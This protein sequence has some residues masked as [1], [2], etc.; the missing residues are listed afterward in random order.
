MYKNVNANI[1]NSLNIH[2]KNK[3]M[4]LDSLSLNSP[5]K[6]FLCTNNTKE[7]SCEFKNN[8]EKHSEMN[9]KSSKNL[10]NTNFSQ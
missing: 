7:K 4:S 9:L 5:S 10:K 2:N 6:R 3:N 1:P 8:N